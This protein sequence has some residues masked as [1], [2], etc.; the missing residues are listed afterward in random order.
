MKYYS[1]NNYASIN[2]AS[3]KED[4]DKYTKFNYNIYLKTIKDLEN[5]YQDVFI[6]GDLWDMLFSFCEYIEDDGYSLIIIDQYKNEFDD[7]KKSI[8]LKKIIT[9]YSQNKTI[10]FIIASS[11]ND[12]TVKEDLI[13]DL[14]Y[15]FR[16]SIEF[17]KSPEPLIKKK[18]LKMNY[19]KILNLIIIIIITMMMS[20]KNLLIF[21][22]SI[23]IKLKIQ[24]KKKRMK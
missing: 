7:E 13:A 24:I 9:Q 20:I 14:I 23:L 11:L 18:I 16:E 19:L 17:L 5:K 22:Y 4:I 6:K 10:K 12:N 1:S 2:D 15:I 21:L 3:S 8:N